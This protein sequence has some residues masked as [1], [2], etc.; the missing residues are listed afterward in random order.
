MSL[1]DSFN[2][3][4]LPPFL[5]FHQ[6]LSIPYKQRL[7]HFRSMIKGFSKEYLAKKYLVSEKIIM[8]KVPTYVSIKKDFSQKKTRLKKLRKRQY[9]KGCSILYGE[10]LRTFFWEWDQ[11]LNFY[12]LISKLLGSFQNPKT[13]SQDN[14]Y[15]QFPIEARVHWI[16]LKRCRYLCNQMEVSTENVVRCNNFYI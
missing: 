14:L 13:Y 7:V 9:N 12:L 11:T 15:I 10:M 6:K 16:L 5:S 1:P 2:F 3:S 4:D 8:K